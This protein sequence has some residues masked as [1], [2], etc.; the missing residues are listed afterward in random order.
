MTFHRFD[1][2]ADTICLDQNLNIYIYQVVSDSMDV[3][4]QNPYSVYLKGFVYCNFITSCGVKTGL[5]GRLPIFE[6]ICI[7][8]HVF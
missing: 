3:P 4:W 5:V 8:S 2:N 6:G 1:H 7:T